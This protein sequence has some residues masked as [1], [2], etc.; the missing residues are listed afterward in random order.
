ML[1]SLDRKDYQAVQVAAK[2][3]GIANALNCIPALAPVPREEL[4]RF[5][6]VVTEKRLHENT[7]VYAAGM[8]D[9][10]M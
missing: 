6:M 7:Y 9:D 3:N 8:T 10:C 4:Q 5:A 2:I 1:W